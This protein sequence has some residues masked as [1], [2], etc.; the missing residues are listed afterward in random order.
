MGVCLLVCIEIIQKKKKKK[1]KF[2]TE[3][4]LS[5]Q[6]SLRMGSQVFRSSIIISFWIWKIYFNSALLMRRRAPSQ[7]LFD[8]WEKMAY[9]LFCCTG[10]LFI[11]TNQFHIFSWLWM[12]R[13]YHYLNYYFLKFCFCIRICLFLHLEKRNNSQRWSG[14][15][16]HTYQAILIV[17]ATLKE[18]PIDHI[19]FSS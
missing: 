7:S 8:M 4:I 16:M 13:S 9:F 3:M 18:V 1:K 19:N 6:G 15:F 14:N 11:Q 10:K 17:T 5:K 12:T 2:C